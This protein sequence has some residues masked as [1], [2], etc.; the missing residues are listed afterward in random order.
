MLT[1][2][3]VLVH[4]MRGRVC[5]KVTKHDL[6]G[7]DDPAQLTRE[8]TARDILVIAPD[9]KYF[10]PNPHYM[11]KWDA[12]ALGRKAAFAGVPLTANPFPPG[13]A[14]SRWNEAHQREWKAAQFRNGTPSGHFSLSKLL[15]QTN[16]AMLRHDNSFENQK[17]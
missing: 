13:P 3:D 9:P 4:R 16:P 1:K 6:F 5:L 15:L 8:L 2:V 11:L 7:D 12:T 10:G 14:H 17:P